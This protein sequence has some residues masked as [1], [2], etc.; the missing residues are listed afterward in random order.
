M[1]ETVGIKKRGPIRIYKPRHPKKAL[2]LKHYAVM[3]NVSYAAIKADIHRTLVY[4]WIG[5]YALDKTNLLTM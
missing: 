4:Q 3:G 5:D 1:V 2:F